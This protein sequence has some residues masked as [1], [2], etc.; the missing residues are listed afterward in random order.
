MVFEF[1]LL[2]QKTSHIF[3]SLS[4]RLT[5]NLSFNSRFLTL[6]VQPNVLSRS[7]KFFEFSNFMES[8]FY[9]YVNDGY[10]I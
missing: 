6:L 1:L 7:F 2:Y 8:P 10:T 5:T 3:L 9:I 4:S